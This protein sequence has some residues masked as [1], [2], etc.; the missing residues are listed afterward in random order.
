[1]ISISRTLLATILIASLGVT[2]NAQAPI[3][4]TTDQ[5]RA[6]IAE[7]EHELA[8]LRDQLRLTIPAIPSP[9]RP[10]SLTDGAAEAAKIRHEWPLST[11]T[12]PTAASLVAAPPVG[13]SAFAKDEAL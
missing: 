9:V 10:W 2:L 6:R 8:A 13:A 4:S 11:K 12:A 1:M 7:R 3:P 5:L